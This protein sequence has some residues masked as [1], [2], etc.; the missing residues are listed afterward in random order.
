MSVLCWSVF[1]LKVE[2]IS[3]CLFL[4]SQQK[5]SKFNLN[6]WLIV[7]DVCEN[8]TIKWIKILLIIM[9]RCGKLSVKLVGDSSD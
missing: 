2:N 3:F 8:L 1:R 4:F 6:C 9:E 5:Q 7:F